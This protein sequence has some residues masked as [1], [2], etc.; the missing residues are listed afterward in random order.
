MS[1]L[2]IKPVT[3]SGTKSTTSIK[4]NES[5]FAVD[6]KNHELLKQAYLTHLANKRLSSARTKKRGEVRGGGRK[7]WQ[8][9]GTGRAR[10][11]SI[12]SPIWRGGGITFGPTGE[13]NHTKHLSKQS[14]QTS[15]KQALTLAHESS[16]VIIVDSADFM[17]KKTKDAAKFLE[18][19]NAK[20]NV[21]CVV[22]ER[23]N[24]NELGVRNIPYATVISAKYLNAYNVLNANHIVITKDALTK[25]EDWLTGGEQ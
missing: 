15:L 12:R 16:K 10:A 1:D 25:I 9:K 24:D 18:K 14:R 7:P 8:Q 17:T 19:L 20:R 6:V 2:S 3:K 13:E 5:V 11:G 22:A 23:N 4:L 21:L